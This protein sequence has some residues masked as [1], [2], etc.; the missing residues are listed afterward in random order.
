MFSLKL[1]LLII[2]T[3]FASNRSF[4]QSK[5]L[6]SQLNDENL[7]LNICDEDADGIISLQIEYLEEFVTTSTGIE[8]DML[9]ESVLISTSSGNVLSVINTSTNPQ[10]STICN[11]NTTLTDIAVNSDLQ[12]FV[13][14]GGITRIDDACNTIY[15]GYSF[16]TNNSLSFDDLD[17]LYMGY[18]N[19]SEVLRLQINDVTIS[20]I[21]TW[22][23]FQT[24]TAGGDF[25][26]LNDKIYISWKLSS[27]NYRLYEVTVDEERNYIS[28]IDLGK[29]PNE[30]YGLASEF[31]KLYGVTPEK[32][33]RIETSN[34]SFENVIDNPDPQDLWYG[35]SGLH[36]AIVYEITIYENVSNAQNAI[37]SL[38]GLWNNENGNEALYARIENLATGEYYLVEI[39]INIFTAPDVD[40]PYDITICEEDYD[41]FF[42][43]TQVSQQMGRNSDESLSYT[44]YNVNPDEY[45]LAVP[46]N[47]NYQSFTSTDTLYVRV[48]NG[49]CNSIYSFEARTIPKP[50]VPNLSSST[51]PLFLEFCRID[52]EEN[53]YFD[54]L[55]SRIDLLSDVSIESISFFS[56]YED[57]M[58]SLNEISN[59]QYV[60]TEIIEV[61]ARV[62]N[63]FGC[64]SITNFFL[65]SACYIEN[66]STRDI[67]FPKFFTPN[68]DG[69]NDFWNVSGISEKLKRESNIFILDRFGKMVAEFSPSNG[70]G[71]DGNYNGNPLPSSDYWFVFRTQTGFETKGHFA[72][73]R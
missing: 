33:F 1:I 73:K 5:N 69:Y 4:S 47:T 60:D 42:D 34:F 19:D 54:L 58:E 16:F 2:V 3:L 72:L 7:E 25:V 17:N 38:E 50:L 57:A 39:N 66:P 9:R 20:D 53:G 68:S 45:P 36:E 32:L 15:Y 21:E 65:N 43:L 27:S 31:G 30:A 8:N 64:F 40:S 48:S 28:H 13:S 18:G 51:D 67:S 6:N 22:H 46:M 10:L 14:D 71:W 41:V 52:I 61:F 70:N 35:A 37:N 55:D 56:N 29:L 24:G 23:D 44:Y 62:E 63:R 59:V 26:L 12:I 11:V 49:G